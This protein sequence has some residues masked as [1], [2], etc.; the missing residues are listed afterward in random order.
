ML[1]C[2][3]AAVQRGD[4]LIA[5]RCLVALD[6][7]G[8]PDHVRAA[9]ALAT[10]PALSANE[11]L[12]RALTMLG[13]TNGA[14]RA[15]GIQLLRQHGDPSALTR[16]A[17]ALAVMPADSQIALLGLLEDRA[18]T[19]AERLILP[20]RNAGDPAVRAAALRA[21]GT[22]GTAESVGPL[23]EA[24][25]RGT[26]E[27]RGAARR[28]LRRISGQR[29]N[30]R[31]AELLHAT[32]GDVRLELLRAIGDRG[33]SSLAPT[34]FALTDSADEALRHEAI[35]Q[36]GALAGT[37]EWPRLLDK[38][39]SAT[40]DADRAAW[41]GA[42]EA[43]AIRLSR[44]SVELTRRWK[45]AETPT[46]REALL[47]LIGRLRPPDL[48]PAV[49]QA[50]SSAQP[51]ERHAAIRAL[52]RWADAAA[53]P[54]L[55]AAAR[56]PEAATRRLAQ[57]GLVQVLR[58]AAQ[59]RPAERVAHAAEIAV[60]I[61]HADEQKA[62]LAIL[63]DAATAEAAAVAARFLDQPAVRAEAELAILRSARAAGA[64]NRPP[65]RAALER[66]ARESES[67]DRREEAAKLLSGATPPAQ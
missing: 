10:A 66:I 50:A 28:A 34:V 52:S 53:L 56:H 65:V 35:K 22:A 45:S 8:A 37:T 32:A 27:E 43:A 23:A 17:G 60:V 15:A 42:A 29:V 18:I 19:A 5:E 16:A 12:Y 26:D 7:A 41:L 11:Q 25:A 58:E 47:A 48:L 61:E 49:A 46:A 63:A 31:M 51:N 3:D 9:A 21:L 38:L 14:M 33:V 36:A 55:I 59:L 39:T 4:R 6:G 13:S 2:L 54:P 67:A 24:A 62:L 40:N 30:E 57:R 1:S 64:A 20:L 44:A